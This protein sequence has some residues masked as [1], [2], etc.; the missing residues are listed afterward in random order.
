MGMPAA[1]AHRWT[2]E[3]VLALIDEQEDHSVRYEFADGELLVTPSPGGYHQ[4]IILELFRLLDP[5]VRGHGIGEVRLGP[6]PVML[7]PKTVVQPDLFMVPSIDGRRPRADA[8]VGTL[9]LSV[10]VLSPG[11]RQH[12][13]LTKRHHYQ[14]AGVPVYWIVDQEAAVVE[15]W[16]PAD[17]RPD[18]LDERLTWQ[19]LVSV[20]ALTIDLPRFFRSVL[21]E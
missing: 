21:D 6:S 18:M 19:P 3:K 14:R 8:P 4:R 2:Y 16:R 20:E 7:L 5:Y 17:V 12:D 11:S 9:L 15:R 13:R 1:D 10:E